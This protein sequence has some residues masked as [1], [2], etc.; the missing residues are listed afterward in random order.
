[1][2]VIKLE[3]TVELKLKINFFKIQI[4]TFWLDDNEPQITSNYLLTRKGGVSLSRL[5]SASG[6]TEQFIS[7]QEMATGPCKVNPNKPRLFLFW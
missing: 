5:H 2:G 1:M 6:Q 4:W 7:K 3:I